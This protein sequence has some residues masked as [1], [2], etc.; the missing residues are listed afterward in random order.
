MYTANKIL[1]RL[2]ILAKKNKNGNLSEVG[3][4]LLHEFKK[5]KPY[6]NKSVNFKI[7]NGA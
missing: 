6:G 3:R 1:K 4:E 5:G 2:E 7:Q